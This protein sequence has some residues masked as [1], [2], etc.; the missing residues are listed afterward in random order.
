MQTMLKGGLLAHDQLREIH[1]AVL[2]AGIDREALLTLIDRR[3]TAGFH[4]ASSPGGQ[5]WEDLVALNGIRA[6]KDG[7]AP[8]VAWLETARHLAEPR[9]EAGIFQKALD[10]LAGSPTGTRV[11]RSV[12][13]SATPDAGASPVD[14]L[15]VTVLPEEYAAVLRL[16]SNARSVQGRPDAPTLYGWR[17]GTVERAQGGAYRVALA[18][19]GR[20]GTVNASQ[21]VVRSVDRWKPRYVLLVGIAGGLPPSGCSVGAVVVSTEIYGYEYGKVDNGFHPRP[22][23]V[24]QVDRGLCTSAQAFVA[25]TPEWFTG[26]APSPKVLFGPVASGDKVVDDPSEPFFAAVLKQWPKLQA[27]EMEGAGAAAA[28]DELHAMGVRVG[29]LMVRGISDMPRPPNERAGQAAQT[30]ERDAN[31]LRACDVAAGFA[32]RWIA[33]E[34]PVEPKSLAD[35]P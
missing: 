2:S 7:S 6:L 1:D 8:L 23:W 3:L 33:A 31:T 4:K 29:F 34:W 25:A 27:V 21:A 18:L 26:G 24:Y 35:P 11:D 13:D 19:A 17:I 15:I 16:L 32:V 9:A 30:G 5:V 12:A 28:I 14:I 20:A 22:N 10:L